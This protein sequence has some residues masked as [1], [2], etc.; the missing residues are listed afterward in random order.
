MI[1]GIDASLRSTAIVNINE[2]KNLID[3]KL[4]KS[5]PNE[6]KTNKNKPYPVFNDEDLIIYNSKEVVSFV[7][8]CIDKNIINGIVIEGLSF[9]GLS[10]SKDII[11]GSFWNILVELKKVF[12]DIPRGRIPVS[13]W[14]SPLT[15]KEERKLYK[16]KYG[17]KGIKE[18]IVG[19]LPKEIKT[20]FE[21]YIKENKYE[22]DGIYDLADAYFICCFRLGLEEK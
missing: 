2:N 4:I 11:Q 22:K 17:K 15:T 18:L 20:K 8:K 5:K 6:I 10:G 21:K 14:R 3:F 19:K 16:E 7:K 1:I 9:A 13:S 12:P